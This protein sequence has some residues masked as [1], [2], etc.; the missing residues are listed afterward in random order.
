MPNGPKKTSQRSCRCALESH[1]CKLVVVTGGPGA[2]KTALLEMVRRHFCE[3]VAVLP[4]S[5]SIVFGGGFPRRATD[6]ARRAAQRAIFRVQVELERM[7]Q[8]EHTAAVALC[9]RGTV[10]GLAYWPGDPESFWRA[11]D[12]SRDEQLA[13][14][15]AV[16][17]LR[18]PAAADYN[19]E[20]PL[21]IETAREAA[22]L[23]ERIAAAWR[24][25]PRVFFVDHAPQFLDKVAHALEL[26]RHEIPDCCQ[27][28]ELAGLER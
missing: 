5:A 27:A 24:G 20:N 9:D 16:I 28:H 8:E 14:Y 3:H 25:H 19:H 6:S 2:G 1:P 23:D 17:H 18:T 12:T 21:R 11:H 10:D 7:V 15:H 26:I 22:A 4:E 13:H